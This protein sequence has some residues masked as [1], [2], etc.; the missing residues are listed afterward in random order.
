MLTF[1]WKR[2][3]AALG[4][5]LLLVLLLALFVGYRV[6][7]AGQ[8]DDD[9]RLAGK[10]DYL[11]RIGELALPDNAPNIVFILYDDMGY[12]DIGA[13]ARTYGR[14][15]DL[16]ATP[17]I[18][19]LAA[20]GVVLT[21]FHS[22]SPVCTPSRAGFLTG[23]LAPRA[24]LP[25]VVFPT[26]SLK[27]F[28]F[29][30]VAAPRL[31]VRLP[32]EEITLADILKA[33]GYATG[34]VG[35]W[36]L[37]DRSPS[38]PNDMGF[39][40][41]FG[42]LYSND[43]EPFALYTN[44]TVA[45]PAPADQRLLTE[46]YTEAA[47]AFIEYH[48]H[49]PFF[50]YFAHNFPHDPLSV[51]EARSGRSRA[52]LYGDVLEEIDDSVG[53]IVDTLAR[54]GNLD[55]TLILISSDNGPWFLGDAGDQRGRKGNTF[56]GGT[57]V[58]F[59]AYWPREIAGHRVEHAMAMGIDLV[60]T[61]LDL[62]HL[63]SP[64]DRLLDGRS[65]LGVLTRGDPSP[66]DYLYYYEGETLFAVR[67]QRFKYRGPAGVLYGT[68]QMPL[69]AAVPQKEWLFDLDGDPREAYDTSARYPQDL[70]RLRDVFA[71]KKREMAANPRGWQ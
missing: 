36:H 9:A 4:T 49:E 63:P 14:A 67:D 52:G 39:D 6:L 45:E 37:G 48:A 15:K 66:H 19:R 26:G 20:D 58:P 16:I 1:I 22:P 35:K 51:R 29:S 43:M 62:L 41:Y 34:M 25:N 21:D 46:R 64:T 65:I 70:Q 30:T 69:G 56:E 27:G 5:L 28:L 8:T 33:A 38:L 55:N 17:R 68:D 42:A 50:L 40:S 47:T 59:I 61:M 2:I 12:G 18:D 32:A 54:T 13:G 11:A 24:G 31:N 57:R 71:E 7:T 60:P 3:T 44:R 10:R 53:I 23:R